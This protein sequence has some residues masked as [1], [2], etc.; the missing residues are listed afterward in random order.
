MRKI[1]INNVFFKVHFGK[2]YFLLG[3]VSVGFN[4][5]VIS[6]VFQDKL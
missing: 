3:F 4:I 6:P 1:K 2:R 5:L